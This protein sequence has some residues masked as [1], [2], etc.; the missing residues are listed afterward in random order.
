MCQ[1]NRITALLLCLLL[2]LPL[3]PAVV[4]AEMQAASEDGVTVVSEVESKRTA[5][6]LHPNNNH[7]GAL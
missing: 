4:T 1:S 6:I 5:A 2:L 7:G 3:F